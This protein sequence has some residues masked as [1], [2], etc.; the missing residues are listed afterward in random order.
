MRGGGAWVRVWKAVWDA[1][2]TFLT[3]GRNRGATTRMKGGGGEAW[4]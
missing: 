4:H 2:K 1:R 3:K